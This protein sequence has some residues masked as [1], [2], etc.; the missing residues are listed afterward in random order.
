MT[1][2][3]VLPF[4][5]LMSYLSHYLGNTCQWPVTANNQVLY[6]TPLGRSTQLNPAYKCLSQTL[7]LPWWCIFKTY[8]SL[9]AIETKMTTKERLPTSSIPQFQL[10]K[11]LPYCQLIIWI[12][13]FQ[14]AFRPNFFQLHVKM[15][16]KFFSP[17]NIKGY[18]SSKELQTNCKGLN[19]LKWWVSSLIVHLW[20]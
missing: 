12:F 16:W 14:I 20:W 1:E 5:I 13:Y 3:R 9:V 8:F 7:A 4:A 6:C 15:S 19:F 2:L 18:F 10:F 17:S 11:L